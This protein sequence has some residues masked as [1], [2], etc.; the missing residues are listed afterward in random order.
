MFPAFISIGSFGAGL[1]AQMIGAQAVVVL[2]AIGAAAVTGIAWTRSAAYRR[3][4]LSTLIA[5]RG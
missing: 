3:L 1:G 4:N 5:G 2:F